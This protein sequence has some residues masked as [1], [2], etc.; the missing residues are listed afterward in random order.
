MSSDATPRHATPLV[1][2]FTEGFRV[3]FLA[4]GLFAVAALV[5]WELWLAI[6][7]AGGMVTATPFA[8]PPHLWHA[9]EMIWGY[10]GAVLGGFFLTA[11]PN[12]TGGR[13]AAAPFLLAVSGLWLAGRAAV[14]VSGSLDPW[15]V[16]AVDLAFLPVLASK[17]VA[18]LIR[19]PKP[20][21][22]MLVGLLMSG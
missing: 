4:A 11:V 8:H 22:L 20:Q 2:P 16:A 17:L 18:M 14:W 9:H 7:A 6:H 5:Y 12:W 21:N 1:T 15:L 3:F 10:A 13:P 19:R